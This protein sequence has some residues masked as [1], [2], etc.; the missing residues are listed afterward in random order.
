MFK[1]LMYFLEIGK[2]NRKM[3]KRL[4]KKQGLDFEALG[5]FCAFFFP[6]KKGDVKGRGGSPLQNYLLNVFSNFHLFCYS[7]NL[8]F[9]QTVH[10]FPVNIR[11]IYVHYFTKDYNLTYSTGLLKLKALR[12]NHKPDT[13]LWF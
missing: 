11:S 5:L 10:L 8:P 7:K 3:K 6:R 9:T 12:I 4:Q 2:G 13:F 1:E